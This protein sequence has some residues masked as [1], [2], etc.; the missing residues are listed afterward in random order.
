MIELFGRLLLN[1]WHILD[2]LNKFINWWVIHKIKFRRCFLLCSPAFS[3]RYLFVMWTFFLFFLKIRISIS[4]QRV[5]FIFTFITD[6]DNILTLKLFVMNI[7]LIFYHVFNPVIWCYFLK[8][9][10][11]KWILLQIALGILFYFS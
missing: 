10:F 4:E 9:I 8:Q 7:S 11:E 6:I 2:F 1:T 5:C 3:S